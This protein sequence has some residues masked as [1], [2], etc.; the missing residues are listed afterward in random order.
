MEGI[1][2]LDDWGLE[3]LSREQSLNM[4]EVL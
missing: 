2:L 4:L 1:L 3:K